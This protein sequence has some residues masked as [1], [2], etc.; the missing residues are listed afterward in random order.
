V[1][2]ATWLQSSSSIDAVSY[3]ANL[4]FSAVTAWIVTLLG[5]HQQSRVYLESGFPWA[6]FAPMLALAKH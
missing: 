1:T 4:V 5:R 6:I 2:S 3:H